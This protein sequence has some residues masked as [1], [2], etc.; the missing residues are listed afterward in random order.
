MKERGKEREGER[1]RA[2]MWT[3]SRFHNPFKKPHN[4]WGGGPSGRGILHIPY[5]LWKK[6]KR[7]RERE[8]CFENG[9]A[10]PDSGNLHSVRYAL[11]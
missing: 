8:F 2:S 10:A 5:A 4:I 3:A 7:E 11:L 1:E 9:G 6:R